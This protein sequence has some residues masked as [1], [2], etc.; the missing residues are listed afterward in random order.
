V[1]QLHTAN[2]GNIV[3][4]S[5]L[6]PGDIQHHLVA[7]NVGNDV[8]ITDVAIQ[9]FGG[10]TTT[11]DTADPNLSVVVHDLIDLVGTGQVGNMLP[12]N[13]HFIS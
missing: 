13:I 8:H 5:S 2:G 7:V 10:F 12:H 4:N 1:N 11:Q 6:N 3:F 9:N